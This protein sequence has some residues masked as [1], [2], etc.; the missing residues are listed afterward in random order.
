MVSGFP[1][2]KFRIEQGKCSR[3][4]IW[5]KS[6]TLIM[7][8]EARRAFRGVCQHSDLTCLKLIVQIVDAFFETSV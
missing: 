5:T 1:K 6:M 8:V 4:N 7:F 2:K 3:E